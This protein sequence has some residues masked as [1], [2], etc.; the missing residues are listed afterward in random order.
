MAAILSPLGLYGGNRKAKLPLRTNTRIHAPRSTLRIFVV[1][2][3]DGC[4]ATAPCVASMPAM[5][6]RR[7]SS[8]S[9]SPDCVV[10]HRS[11][12][13][14]RPVRCCYTFVCGLRSWLCGSTKEPS[15]FFGEPL[16]TRRIRCSLHQS[17]L[18]TRLPRCPSSTLVLRFNQETVH[19][20]ILPF[21]PPRGPHLTTLATKSLVPSLLVF[22][23][24][25]GLTAHD[26]SHLF[27]T[28]T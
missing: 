8:T 23:T 9:K 7:E 18:M 19:D 14:V 22:S 27:F 17:S 6:F 26:L 13:S 15:G 16:E 21:L 28:H 25:E 5:R 20:L 10:E 1:A 24:H 12:P 2:P 3:S 4:L 11:D